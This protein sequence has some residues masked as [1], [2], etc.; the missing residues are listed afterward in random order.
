MKIMTDVDAFIIPKSRC[1]RLCGVECCW[2]ILS[3]TSEHS[4]GHWNRI[5]VFGYYLRLKLWQT[6][7]HLLC[8][9]RDLRGVVGL[10]IVK[11]FIFRAVMPLAWADPPPP[12]SQK[13]PL[14]PTWIA[15]WWY[16][17]TWWTG[18]TGSKLTFYSQSLHDSQSSS[19][20]L[21]S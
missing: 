6:L 8:R 16:F 1:E 12:S 7:T 3:V 15:I 13:A 20:V 2:D 10:D 11:K 18:C 14:T 17:C 5:E 19:W 21:Y 4:F 9:N